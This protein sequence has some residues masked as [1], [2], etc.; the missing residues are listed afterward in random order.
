[1]LLAFRMRIEVLKNSS[2]LGCNERLPHFVQ[3][4]TV[5]LFDIVTELR[6]RYPQVSALVVFKVCRYVFGKV[7]FEDFVVS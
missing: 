7:L 1:M 6:Q 4:L 5:A 2:I 3:A